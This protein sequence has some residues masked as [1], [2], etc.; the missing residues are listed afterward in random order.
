MTD[1]SSSSSSKAGQCNSIDHC[2]CG[3]QYAP[4]HQLI[5]ARTLN[6]CFDLSRKSS[7]DVLMLLCAAGMLMI[8]FYPS[9]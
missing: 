3:K 9:S 5:R 6:A 4:M 1:T 2:Q 7:A 8:R